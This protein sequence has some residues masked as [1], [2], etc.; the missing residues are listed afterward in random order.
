[1]LIKSKPARLIGS[2]LIEVLVVVTILSFVLVAM[3]NTSIIA[4]VQTKY[5]RNKA[6]AVR[7]TQEGLDWLRAQRDQKDSW[8]EFVNLAF[9]VSGGWAGVSDGQN[10]II[11]LDSLSWSKPQACVAGEYISGTKFMRQLSLTANK[12][13]DVIQAQVT[14]G[15]R[16]SLCQNIND[17][18]CHNVK[19]EIILSPW[20][21]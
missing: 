13:D 15:W 19:V 8:D 7:Y 18:F 16:D 10:R 3:L 6:L 21:N 1:M 4:M 20:Q 2:T 17:Y 12:T 5:A 11:C 9:G 14:A